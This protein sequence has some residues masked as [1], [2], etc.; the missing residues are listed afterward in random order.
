VGPTSVERLLSTVSTGPGAR[1]L[2]SWLLAPASTAEV[3][4][5]QDAVKELSPRID[6]RQEL[7]ARARVAGL[8]RADLTESFLAWAEEDSWLEPRWPLV[9]TARAVPLLTLLLF[10][11]QLAGWLDGYWWLL[12]PFVGIVFLGIW[13]EPIGEVI[14]RISAGQRFIGAYGDPLELLEE[15]EAESKPLVRVRDLAR[16]GEG[17]ASR[18]L[19]GLERWIT[20]AD[21][22][23]NHLIHVPLQVTL[24]W[25]VHVLRALEKWRAR[26]GASVAAWLRAVGEAEA[27]AALAA[28]RADNPGW[29]F[30]EL[31]GSGGEEP[32]MGQGI[33]SGADGSPEGRGK[34]SAGR[35]VVARGVGHPLIPPERSVVNDLE[36]GPPGT[37]LLVTGSNMS[38]K[39]TLL[40]SIGV[41]CVLAL[42]GGPVCASEFRLPRVRILTSM[43][44]ED[45]L[46]RGLSGYMAELRRVAFVVEGSRGN[47][48]DP[49][50]R[51]VPLYL[52]DEPLQGTNEAERREAVRIVLEQLLDAG[53][54]GAVATH[55]LRL[56]HT[57]RLEEAARAVHFTSRV[58]DE[59][60][61]LRLTFDYRLRTGPATSTNALDLL[62]LVGLGREEGS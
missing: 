12:G 42:A 8:G 20:T 34:P 7:A 60:G 37:F 49:A 33:E 3:R 4:A 1:T 31:V 25:D 13:T 59:G 48:E 61:D 46:A 9:W 53:A 56:H 38:G 29:C 14:D 11:C 24:F 10:L 55:D 50:S 51:G 40:R 22:R 6:L 2:R 23:Y 5:R 39:S 28:L 30:P 21:V 58:E 18:A 52:L 35:R 32:E 54:I 36:V 43:R 19:R 26:N 45:S 16:S 27:L 62:R 41:N 57:R 44:T 47:G 15:L 17:S